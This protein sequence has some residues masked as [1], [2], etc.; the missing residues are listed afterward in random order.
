MSNPI[1]SS[2]RIFQNPPISSRV[3]A[4]FTQQPQCSL[5][6]TSCPPSS[7]LSSPT[8]YAALSPWPLYPGGYKDM[9]SL[10]IPSKI[11]PQAS[12]FTEKIDAIAKKLHWLF[13]LFGQLFSQIAL[14]PIDLFRVFDQ[15]LNSC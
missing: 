1:S 6:P 4:I 11:Q 10:N 7:L 12:H 8:L 9:C 5:R 13:S 15:L 14:W 3:K 2:L